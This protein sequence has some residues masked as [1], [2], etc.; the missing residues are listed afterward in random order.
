M[1]VTASY[2]PD[3]SQ[4]DPQAAARAATL[5][6]GIA[7]RQVPPVYQSA[8]TAG[9]GTPGVIAEYGHPAFLH[10]DGTI[11]GADVAALVAPL[12]TNQAADE[13][14]AATLST[15]LANMAGV[16]ATLRTWSTTAAGTTATAGTVVAVVN[17]ILANLSTLYARLA[18]LL[19]TLGH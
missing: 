4:T 15:S 2:I 16:Q 17:G 5:G 13:A 8:V 10:D 6:I 3:P 7:P 18:D 14:A 1:T 11:T 12:N 9:G 19:N